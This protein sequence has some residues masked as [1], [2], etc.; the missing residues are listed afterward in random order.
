[1]A[2]P[3]NLTPDEATGIGS[4]TQAQIISA[5]LSGVDDEGRMLCAVMPRFAALGMKQA[6][7]EDVAAYLKSLPPVVHEIPESSCP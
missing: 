2:Y 5:I 4:W 3:Q 7:A 6:E 1:M